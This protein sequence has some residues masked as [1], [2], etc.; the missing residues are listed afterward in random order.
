[1]E[2]SEIAM[3]Y[4]KLYREKVQLSKTLRKFNKIQSKREY[5]NSEKK[6]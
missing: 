6:I 2:I 4:G 3:L 1:M 5:F